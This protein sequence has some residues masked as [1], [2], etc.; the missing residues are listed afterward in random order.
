ME[1]IKEGQRK[2]VWDYNQ[3]AP[4]TPRP[5]ANGNPTIPLGM[6]NK[7]GTPADVEAKMGVV[8]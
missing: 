4:V 1:L 5:D 3:V 8:K 2:G 7:S 6:S